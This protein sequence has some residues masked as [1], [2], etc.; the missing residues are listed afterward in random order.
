MKLEGALQRSSSFKSQHRQGRGSRGQSLQTRATGSKAGIQ[1]QD[2]HR[3]KTRLP[4]AKFSRA[5]MP[6]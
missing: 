4:R 1:G 3:N 2:F 5:H 6:V